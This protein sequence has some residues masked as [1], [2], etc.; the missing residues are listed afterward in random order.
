MRGAVD[1]LPHIRIAGWDVAVLEDGGAALVEG[2][3]M[4]DFDIL[5]QPL[6]KGVRHAFTQ[7]VREMFGEAYLG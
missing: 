5:Q 4:P 7:R 1:V 2:N 6:G 3:H